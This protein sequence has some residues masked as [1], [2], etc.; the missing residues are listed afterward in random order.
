MR[1]AL[2]S[3]EPIDIACTTANGCF[4]QSNLS[5]TAALTVYDVWGGGDQAR[6]AATQQVGSVVFKAVP[7]GAASV[8]YLVTPAAVEAG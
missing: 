4:Q 1:R 6:P 7:G 5:T 3:S 8:L 2:A